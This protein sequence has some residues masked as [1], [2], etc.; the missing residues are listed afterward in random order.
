LRPIVRGAQNFRVR[1]HLRVERR[2]AAHRILI[3]VVVP[4]AFLVIEDL[5]PTHVHAATRINVSGMIETQAFVV[6]GGLELAEESRRT[7]EVTAGNQRFCLEAITY[8]SLAADDTVE[9][10][11]ERPAGGIVDLDRELKL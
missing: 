9:H 10:L 11:S 7:V 5:H 8:A 4:D 1:M 6:C 3:G 2:H